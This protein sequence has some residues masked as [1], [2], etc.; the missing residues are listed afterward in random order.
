MPYV[1]DQCAGGYPTHPHLQPVASVACRQCLARPL[2]LSSSV[3]RSSSRPE[4]TPPADLGI[5]YRPLFGKQSVCYQV[6]SSIPA[7]AEE[8]VRINLRQVR[9]RLDCCQLHLSATSATVLKYHFHESAFNTQ[10]R[11][12]KA[13]ASRRWNVGFRQRGC[14]WRAGRLSVL[15]APRLIRSGGYAFGRGSLINVVSRS[16][17]VDHKYK[18]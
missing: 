7:V 10:Q 6:L 3:G 15:D 2:R 11:T 1:L 16:I 18:H 8:R 5:A 9:E 13:T 4:R 17:A 14:F 12:A